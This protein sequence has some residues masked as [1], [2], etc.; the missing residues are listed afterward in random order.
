MKLAVL[1]AN[2]ANRVVSFT[3]EMR[4][5]TKNGTPCIKLHILRPGKMGDHFPAVIPAPDWKNWLN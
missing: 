3:K 1:F 4:K 2:L 5:N